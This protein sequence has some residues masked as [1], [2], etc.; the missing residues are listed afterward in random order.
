MNYYE[1]D[2]VGSL[3]KA[4]IIEHYKIASFNPAILKPGC[5][6]IEIPI[7]DQSGKLSIKGTDT[8][9]GTLYSYSGRFYIHNM[10]DEVD[11]TLNNFI[12]KIGV[13]K[14]T[15]MNGRIYII[16]A[17]GM[18]VNLTIVGDTG[19]TFVNEN[20]TEYQFSIDQTFPALK[21]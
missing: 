11:D 13:L 8:D 5:T 19:Q 14:L 4:E 6:W 15:D 9:N 12:G 16:G 18:G 20:G 17:P 10:R 3:A 2:N 1:G 21:I 7:K